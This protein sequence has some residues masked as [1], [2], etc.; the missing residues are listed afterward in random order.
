MHKLKEEESRKLMQAGIMDS[1]D[2]EARD[3]DYFDQY[4]PDRER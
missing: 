3:P 4:L 2:K 1:P